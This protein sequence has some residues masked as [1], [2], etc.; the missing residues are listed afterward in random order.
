MGTKIESRERKRQADRQT[1]LKKKIHV[2]NWAE[3]ENYSTVHDAKETDKLSG[4]KLITNTD[5]VGWEGVARYVF[6]WRQ[7]AYECV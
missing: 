4:A 1:E 2:K 5:A 3:G 7:I 6:H